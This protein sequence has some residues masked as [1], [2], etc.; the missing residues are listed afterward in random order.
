MK[1]LVAWWMRN[2]N[3]MDP[4]IIWAANQGS[5]WT[6]Y[7]GIIIGFIIFVT[8]YT[9]YDV[10][11][12]IAGIFILFSFSMLLAVTLYVNWWLK[13]QKNGKN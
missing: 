13:N 6:S 7:I 11:M 3:W 9:H 12:L 4:I 1:K 5:I 10:P 2:T 8:A